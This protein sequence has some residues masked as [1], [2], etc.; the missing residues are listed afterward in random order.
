MKQS[1]SFIDEPERG[2]AH[3]DVVVPP[4][5]EVPSLVGLEPRVA[6]ERV[7]ELGLTPAV[8]SHEAGDE[9]LQGLVCAQEPAPGTSVQ[10]EAVVVL[11]VGQAPAEEASEEPLESEPIEDGWFDIELPLPDAGPY[12]PPSAGE[13]HTTAAERSSPASTRGRFRD[14]AGSLSARW[15]LDWRPVLAMAVGVGL[16]LALFGHGSA[17]RQPAPVT[18]V[19]RRA[20]SE[21]RSSAPPQVAGEHERLRH[22]RGRSHARRPQRPA[23]AKRPVVPHQA[24]VDRRGRAPVWSSQPAVSAPAGS[25]S[26]RC[27]F[28]LELAGR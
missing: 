13:D 24:P 5:V 21:D 8:E 9:P 7:R 12:R 26:T 27:E 20:P 18:V 6:V 1:T 22:R 14:A 16:V 23:A 15:R 11:F 10:G 3:G 19:M 28:C 25:V 4:T 17:D 2:D